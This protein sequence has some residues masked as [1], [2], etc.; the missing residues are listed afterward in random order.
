MKW[1][2][3][4]FE[5]VALPV[6][7]AIVSGPFGSNIGSRFFVEEGVP[8]IRGNNLTFGQRRFIDD[9]FVYLTEEKAQEFRNCE[10]VAADLIFTAAGTIGQVGII[11]QDARFEFP[12]RVGPGYLVDIAKEDPE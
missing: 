2:L 7:G 10:A 6:K 12:I 1:P 9:G 4:K 8:V 3:A 5:E 11:P